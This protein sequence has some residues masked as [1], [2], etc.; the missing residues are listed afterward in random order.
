MD[1]INVWR[2]GNFRIARALKNKHFAKKNKLILVN[3][4]KFTAVFQEK[5][6]ENGVNPDA[7]CGSQGIVMKMNHTSLEALRIKF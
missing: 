7:C 5:K 6:L 2:L 1:F 4:S 3:F